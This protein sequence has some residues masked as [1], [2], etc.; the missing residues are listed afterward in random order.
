MKKLILKDSLE[1]EDL[2]CAK[3]IL[4]LD[5][6]FFMKANSDD[7]NMSLENDKQYYV[8]VED[9]ATPL[10]DRISLGRTLPTDT[11]MMLD[12]KEYLIDSTAWNLLDILKN[13]K[14]HEDL[15]SNLIDFI[16]V[17]CNDDLV[18]KS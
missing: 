6:P 9:D 2:A 15:V 10:L 8:I 17:E 4:D 18:N 3:S 14:S 5:V 16:K 12:N 7:V 1:R 11:T 13:S